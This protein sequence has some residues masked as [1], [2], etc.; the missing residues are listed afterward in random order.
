MSILGSESCLGFVSFAHADLVEARL[1]IDLGKYLCLSKA[2]KGFMNV[3]KRCSILDGLLI[4]SS[5]VEDHPDFSR[6]FGNEEKGGP[7]R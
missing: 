1:E 6:F 3:W 7:V 5:V 2:I 4:K